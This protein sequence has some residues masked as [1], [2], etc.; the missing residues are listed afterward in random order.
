MSL[1]NTSIHQ[2]GEIPEI[3]K[4]P[5]GRIRVVRRFQKFTREDVDN[6]N[7]GSLM[8]NFGDLDTAGEQVANQGYTN[9]RLISV[10][11]DNGYSSVSNTDKPVLVKTYETLTNSFVQITDDT[12]TFTESGL[13]QITRV[14]RAI[15]GTTSSNVVGTTALVTGEI[16]ASSKIEDNDAF[17]ELTETYIKAGILSVQQELNNGLKRVSVQAFNLDSA[18][19]SA[20]LSEITVEHKLIATDESDYG[21][22]K[23][24]TFQYQIDESFKE[25]YELNGLKRISLIEL[26]ATNFTAQDVG[27]VSTKPPTNGLYL[28]TQSIDNGGVIKV[29]QSTWFEDGVLSEVI[30]SAPNPF[31]NCVQ[32]TRT[33]VGAAASIPDGVLI[34]SRDENSNGFTTFTRTTIK[35]LGEDSSDITGIVLEYVDIVEVQAIGTV[36]LVTVSVK[37]GSMAIPKHT[38]PRVK[39]VSANVVVKITTEPTAISPSD[40]AFNLEDAS[41]SVTSVSS[42]ERNSSGNTVSATS[43]IFTFSR[44]GWNKAVS[45][46]AR[47]Q[48]YDGSYLDRESINGSVTY[49]SF[50]SPYLNDSGNAILLEEGTA[51]ETTQCIGSGQINLPPSYKEYGL[52]KRTVNLVLT[53][54]NG[55]TYY[56]ETSYIIPQ[57]QQVVIETP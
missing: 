14:Y 46:S 42:E 7:L 22:I 51:S 20:A 39:Q 21:G 40:I 56:E 4:L 25:D 55:T 5:N 10:E 47:I 49:K 38:P 2:R 43:G 26:S 48:T 17:A 29:R 13:K 45:N 24:T 6:E 36:E 44:T 52:I 9:C 8:G 3:T 37:E 32:I 57:P 41:C 31:K 23:T 27:S 54:L 30:T 15:S 50:E 18:A 33:S 35:S 12:V 16:L 34:D 1:G 11:V 28:G 19:V 53:A